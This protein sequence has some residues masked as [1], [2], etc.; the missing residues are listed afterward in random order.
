MADHDA[1]GVLVAPSVDRVVGLQYGQTVGGGGEVGSIVPVNK[2]WIDKLRHVA[3]SDHVVVESIQMI[4]DALCTCGVQVG[5]AHATHGRMTVHADDMQRRRRTA[6]RVARRSSKAAAATSAADGAVAAESAGA[7]SPPA[8]RA[9]H[10]SKEATA[11]DGGASTALT[12]TPHQAA[13]MSE[14]IGNAQAAALGMHAVL[15]QHALSAIPGIV[16]S[17]LRFGFAL[18]RCADNGALTCEEPVGYT[19][20]A[21]FDVRHGRTYFAESSA[22]QSGDAV[23][24]VGAAAASNTPAGSKGGGGG[25]ADALLSE[26]ELAQRV[27]VAN[28][29]LRVYV[30]DDWDADGTPRSRLMACVPLVNRMV[31]MRDAHLQLAMRAANNIVLAQEA[32]EAA[33]PDPTHVGLLNAVYEAEERENARN[34]LA[35]ARREAQYQNENNA[36]ERDLV[37]TRGG[38]MAQ[39]MPTAASRLA[40]SVEKPNT[41]RR[42]GLRSVTVLD[43]KE[44][45]T[46]TVLPNPE[47]PRD[48]AVA[49]ESYRRDVTG[50][51]GVPVAFT[52]GHSQA[53]A[54][55]IEANKQRIENTMR[56]FAAVLESIFETEFHR[57]FGFRV[58]V[59]VPKQLSTTDARELYTEGFLT[60]AAVVRHMAA[61]LHIPR[62]DFRRVPL[63]R[64]TSQPQQQQQ[65]QR[66]PLQRSATGGS[67]GAP[68]EQTAAER[69]AARTRASDR[70]RPR[71]ASVAS[72][73]ASTSTTDNSDGTEDDDDYITVRQYKRHA[74]A[75]RRRAADATSAKNSSDDSSGDDSTAS[76]NS[77]KAGQSA[78]HTDAHRARRRRKHADQAA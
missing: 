39:E 49:E 59:R 36:V 78:K 73:D 17:L 40:G 65:Q 12:T 20:Y 77:K 52:T 70:A 54:A 34:D 74:H 45:H 25:A 51:L 2:T 9:A 15:A 48:L 67:T 69:A 21:Y 76:S 31:V 1:S 10:D 24:S 6:L 28:R 22:Q 19:I 56:A 27:A 13:D 58:P 41:V 68:A 42:V 60:S 26:R 30:M 32:P 43:V 3:R 72:S 18:V 33:T 47:F 55:Q 23:G 16:N 66:R 5:D 11:A 37:T 64:T 44:G 71:S 8:Q 7:A 53:V 57:Q 35:D 50:A 63:L 14:R 38:L 62:T 61:N 46:L 29:R 4:V 75:R